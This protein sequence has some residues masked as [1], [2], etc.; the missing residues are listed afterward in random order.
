MSSRGVQASA[1]KKAMQI[2]PD[3]RLAFVACEG[4]AKLVAMAAE[5]GPVTAFSETETGLKPLAQHDVGPNAHSVAVDADTGHVY[6][7]IANLGRQPVLREASVTTATGG[8]D[9]DD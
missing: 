2:S 9:D 4:N 8:D 5:S 1:A 3:R 7:P 6:L